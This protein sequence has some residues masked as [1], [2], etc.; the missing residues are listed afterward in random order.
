[1]Q[2]EK[3]CELLE[4][5]HNELENASTVDISTQKLLKDLSN[6]IQKILKE[7]EL[8]NIKDQETIIEKLR[9]IIHNFEDA[10]PT[11]TSVLGQILDSLSKMGI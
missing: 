5:L 7:S 10:H 8:S 3:L 9:Q 4:Q 1:M 6:D 11:L 2:K